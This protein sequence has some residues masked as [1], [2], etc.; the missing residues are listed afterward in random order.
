MYN[1]QG[2][3]GGRKQFNDEN[4]GSLHPRQKKTDKSPDMGGEINLSGDVLDHIRKAI[5]S[6][7]PSVRISLSAWRK[8]GRGNTS[9]MSLAAQIPWKEQQGG[10]T[11]HQTGGGYNQQA[12]RTQAQGYNQAPLEQ[13]GGYAEQRGGGYTGQ[14]VD[15]TDNYEERQDARYQGKKEWER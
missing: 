10:Q 11:Y 1:N 8:M 9:F 13:R 5:E 15:R 14:R 6:G 2:G 7:Q 3:F 12:T 4:S